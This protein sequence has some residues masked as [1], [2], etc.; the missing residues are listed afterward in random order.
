M[1]ATFSMQSHL[2]AELIV[3]DGSIN[4]ETKIAV[5]E[6]G[7]AHSPSIHV[8]WVRAEI[9]GAAAQ[10]NQ[11]ILLSRQ[12]Y[13]LFFDDDILF[14]PEC[15]MHLWA[16]M[17][18]NR[19]LGGVSAMITNQKYCQPGVISRALFYFMHGEALETFA[20]R[21]IGPAINLLPEDRVELP[22]V[23][24]TQWLNT[25]CTIYR[26]NALP[27]PAFDS[28]F[29]RYSLMED[30]A[31]S[32][33][34]GK[35]CRLANVRSARIFHD[36]QPGA[37]KSDPCAR[38]EMELVNRHYVM[39]NVLERTRLRDYVRLFIWEAFTLVASLS[40][41]EGRRTFGARLR[42]Q[43]LGIRAIWLRGAANGR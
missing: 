36:S 21:V 14:S 29:T 34:V 32:L 24:P 38:A 35:K 41:R 17:E 9:P 19:N 43:M 33:Q 7:I 1:L 31:L 22:E 13:I 5:E 23:V 2:P 11:G 15:I 40:S 30:L 6:F 39:T 20:G 42:G 26:A 4:D 28:I 16:A 8:L 10:R 12:K 25:T 27:T 3:I 37:Y 18:G